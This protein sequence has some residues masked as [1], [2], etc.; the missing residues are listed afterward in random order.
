MFPVTA[1]ALL[2]ASRRP[3]GRL[4]YTELGAGRSLV[5]GFMQAI[6]ILP[7]VSRSGSTISGG[8]VVGLK[9]EP[10]AAFAFLLAIPV[11]GGA[12]LLKI[13]DA[14]HKGSTGTPVPTLIVG[15]VVSMLVGLVA[16]RMLLGWVRR[17]T[18]WKF[19]YYLVPL[20]IVVTVWQLLK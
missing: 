14:V 8:L 5:I 12:G 10:A 7:G 2:W 19:A 9:R 20:G 11:I 1:A 3:E 17:G 16:L 6:A 13:L 15:F 4:H 18:L